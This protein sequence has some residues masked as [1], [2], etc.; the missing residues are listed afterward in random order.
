MTVTANRS[1]S[2][3]LS[4]A[5]QYSFFHDDLQSWKAPLQLHFANGVKVRHL[6]HHKTCHIDVFCTSTVT[7]QLSNDCF[8][9]VSVSWTSPSP[10]HVFVNCGS[11]SWSGVIFHVTHTN[12]IVIQNPLFAKEICCLLLL[13]CNCLAIKIQFR[14]LLVFKSVWH[15][16]IS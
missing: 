11:V 13:T 7:I 2:G 10:L 8:R 5:S 4:S 15:F 12:G 6:V 16:F 1:S 14:L 3:L 9:D